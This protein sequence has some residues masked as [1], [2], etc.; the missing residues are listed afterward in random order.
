MISLESTK[1]VYLESAKIVNL[2]F[3][4]LCFTNFIENGWTAIGIRHIESAAAVQ[5]RS[6][7]NVLTK[8]FDQFRTNC[9]LMVEHCKYLLRSNTCKRTFDAVGEHTP[10]DQIS[11]CLNES[12]G[13]DELATAVSPLQKA[14]E[15]SPLN[16]V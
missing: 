2:R 6:I 13:L 4:V 3:G 5:L 11:N 10:S 7:D 16:S 14:T 12:V 15:H 1:I 8:S 9:V